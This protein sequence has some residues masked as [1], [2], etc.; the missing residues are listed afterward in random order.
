MPDR[1]E[2]LTT[3]LTGRYEI[4]REIG[5]GGMATVY[6]ARDIKHNRQVAVKVLRPDLA[7]ALG[8]ERFLREIEI[9]A[10]LTHPHILPLYDSGEADG[11]LYYVMPYIE[12]DTLRDRI[13]KEGEL[14]VTEAVRIIREVADALAFAH[15]QGVVH[16]DIKPDNVMLSGRHAMVT[17]FGVAKAVSEATGRSTLTTAGVALGTPTYMAPEQAT[18]D[19]H[20]DHRA[21]IYAI[22][23]MAYELLAG[24]TPFQG[25]SPQAVLAAHVT[26]E[27]VPVTRHRD[28][29]SA[30]LESV[31]MRCLAK[32]PADR[33]QSADEMLPYL[34]TMTTSS[35]GLTPTATR[36][37]QGITVGRS[38]RVWWMALGAAAA[39]TV[40]GVFGARLMRETPLQVRVANVRQI[41][42]SPLLEIFPDISDDGREIVYVV[43]Q[44]FDYGVAV[45]DTEGGPAL[46]LSADRSGLPWLPR[47]SPSGREVR[48]MEFTPSSNTLG[49]IPASLEVPRFGGQARLLPPGLLTESQAVELYRTGADTI[50]VRATGTGELISRLATPAMET[51]GTPSPDGSRIAFVVGNVQYYSPELLGNDV[52]AS[53]WVTPAG[54]WSPVRVTEDEHL[55]T[56]PTWV[57]NDR[58]LFVSNRE[59][60]RDIYLVPLRNSGEPAA[61]PV[62]VTTGADVHTMSVTP[63]GRLAAYSKLQ[64]RSNLYEITLPPEGEVS[65]NTARPLTRESAVIEQHDRSSDAEWLVYDSNVLGQQDIFVRSV[66]GGNAS[67]LTVDP[68]QDMDPHLSPE[69]SEVVFYSTRHGSRDIY[70]I[71][72]DGQ[73][74]QRLTGDESDG[75]HPQEQEVFPLFSPDGRHIAFGAARAARHYRLLVMSRDTVGGPWGAPREVVAGASPFFTW[76]SS[77]DHLIYSPTA[78]GLRKVRLT[79]EED[80]AMDLGSTS[81]PAWPYLA[82]DGR[83]FYRA[84]GADGVRGIFA[85]ALDGSEPQRVVR[86]DASGVVSSGFGITVRDSSLVLTVSENESDIY[87][88][89]LEY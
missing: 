18:A 3:A 37:L 35:G 2:D 20:V 54:A 74:E 8:H 15:S 50:E 47:W 33:W 14:P 17:D 76:T 51:F 48:F 9:A 69:G 61:A 6:L 72:I 56:H 39:V 82:P 59:G 67:R 1:L 81:E 44:W 60:R 73:N 31:V 25:A 45:R 68:G 12:G 29:V 71:D 26:E 40:L 36:P 63:D 66:A 75:W 28:Q 4:D 58:L 46:A 86:F 77:G 22:G 32:K 38:S 11:F 85:M 7:A 13:E 70:L 19:P 89:E 87:L 42:H 55:D 57:G 43:G 84:F 88:M 16:R 27:A 5:Q 53:L 83:L 10:N 23:V 65:L 24:R 30:E 64:F 34:E 41:T 21:D 62:R 52:P 78:G 80:T 49:T 79:G